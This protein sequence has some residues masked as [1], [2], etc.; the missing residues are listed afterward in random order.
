MQN[1]K[2]KCCFK[3]LAKTSKFNQIEIKC[4]RCKTL[5]NFQSTSSALPII[6]TG[7]IDEQ[8]FCNSTIQS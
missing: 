8:H 4:P 2:C 5:N 6:E 1:L 3:L 7:K